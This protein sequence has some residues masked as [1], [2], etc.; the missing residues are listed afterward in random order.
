MNFSVNNP[1]PTISAISPGSATAG[2]GAFMPHDNRD[3][4]YIRFRGSLE[5]GGAADDVLQPHAA[6]GVDSGQR[7]YC[8]R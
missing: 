8:S 6:D 1:L 7:H 4:L 3:R 5:R 2:S